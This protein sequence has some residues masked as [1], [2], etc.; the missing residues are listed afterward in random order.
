MGLARGVFSRKELAEL[1]PQTIASRIRDADLEGLLMAG[2]RAHRARAEAAAARVHGFD[3]R[4]LL[5][6]YDAVFGMT[7]AARG[8]V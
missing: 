5:A 8:S 2:W 1:P 6:G 3:P 7:L 4:P